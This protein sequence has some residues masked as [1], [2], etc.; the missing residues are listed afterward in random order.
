VGGDG[1]DGGFFTVGATVTTV[2]P[3]SNENDGGSTPSCDPTKTPATAEEEALAEMLK[4][5]NK[6]LDKKPPMTEAEKQHQR[7]LDKYR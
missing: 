7:D 3:P 1:N 5:A 4:A 2:K 6:D